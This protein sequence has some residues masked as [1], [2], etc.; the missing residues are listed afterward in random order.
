MGF[1]VGDGELHGL[2]RL[3]D[4]RELHLAGAEAVADDLHAFE[5]VVVD[6]LEGPLAFGEGGVEVGVE[7]VLVA[8]D[9]ALGEA[10]AEGSAA[11]ASARASLELARL[12]PSKISMSFWSGS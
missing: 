2:G 1:E 3:E 12:T 4:E 5:Q 9:D 7:A 6:D 11:R 8:V 10:L